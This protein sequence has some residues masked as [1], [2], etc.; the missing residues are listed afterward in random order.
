MVTPDPIR[1]YRDPIL[2]LWQ[3]AVQDVISKRRAKYATTA[4]AEH[5]LATEPSV[6]SEEQLMAPASVIGEPLT[7]GQQL[8]EKITSVAGRN[9]GDCR[10]ARHSPG[11]RGNRCQVPV[12]RDGGQEGFSG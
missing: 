5:A 7:K 9:G 6:A 4:G 11:L 1:T 8:P 10:G 3:S 2:S 12:G